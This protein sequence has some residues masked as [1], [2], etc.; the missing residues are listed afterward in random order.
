MDVECF[1]GHE[2]QAQNLIIAFKEFY[3]RSLFSSKHVKE[4]F[5]FLVTSE[6]FRHDK[7]QMIIIC[8]LILCHGY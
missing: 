8:K 4:I 3:P 6:L 1:D 7:Q 5:C 2:N